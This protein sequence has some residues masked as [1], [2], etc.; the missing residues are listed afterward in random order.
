MSKD[1]ETGS[2][3]L[4]NRSARAGDREGTPEVGPRGGVPGKRAL[5]DG[6]RGP[7]PDARLRA[8]LALARAQ[9][10][11]ARAEHLPRLRGS[12]AARSMQEARTAAGDLVRT[13]AT[14][15]RELAAARRLGGEV[16][17]LTAE[18]EAL[19]AEAA[20]DLALAPPTAPPLDDTPWALAFAPP[21][22]EYVEA[23][24][25]NQRTW[26]EQLDQRDAAQA[27]AP[28]NLIDA[29]ARFPAA[30]VVQRRAG[31]SPASDPSDLHRHAAAGVAGAGGALPHLVAI[32]RSFGRHDVS[33]V[34]AHI[35][36]AAAH[37]AQAIGAEAYATGNDVAFA[38]APSL[39]TAAHEAAHVVQQQS[40]VQL[41]GGVGEAGDAHEQHADAV[42]DRV[43]RGESA[44]DLLSNSQS[45]APAANTSAGQVQRREKTD[46][47]FLDL[48]RRENPNPSRGGKRPDEDSS[49]EDKAGAERLLAEDDYKRALTAAQ[50]SGRRTLAAMAMAP[51]PVALTIGKDGCVALADHLGMVEAAGRSISPEAGTKVVDVMAIVHQLVDRMN[52]LDAGDVAEV[53]TLQAVMARVQ[54]LAPEGSLP[55]RPFADANEAAE[56]SAE[57][58]AR[59]SRASPAR[60]T[61]RHLEAARNRLD[62]ALET[63]R[64]EIVG[65]ERDV[66]KKEAI[67][68]AAVDDV[69]PWVEYVARTIDR[70]D[71]GIDADDPQIRAA[72]VEFRN[73]AQR[74][75]Y[76]AVYDPAAKEVVELIVAPVERVTSHFGLDPLRVTGQTGEEVSS[77]MRGPAAAYKTGWEAVYKAQARALQGLIDSEDQKKEPGGWDTVLFAALGAARQ[78]GVIGFVA[79]T[80]TDKLH[81]R[82]K[83]TASDAMKAIART[84]FG[85][86]SA[87]PN[88]NNTLR[89]Q[90]FYQRQVALVELERRHK[91]EFEQRDLLDA[92]RDPSAADRIEAEA[93]AAQRSADEIQARYQVESVQDW[94]TQMA[95]NRYGTNWT[96]GVDLD[97]AG[98]FEK[99]ATGVLEITARMAKPGQRPTVERAVIGS[100]RADDA[101]RLH[102]QRVGDLTLPIQVH[103]RVETFEALSF[104]VSRNKEGTVW[105]GDTTET[106]KEWLEKRGRGDALEG[107][108]LLFDDMSVMVVD[109]ESGS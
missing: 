103:G 42:A 20:A 22:A 35:G 107:A 58:D 71:L 104:V 18:L 65:K 97:N 63:F 52:Q 9:I 93:E 59:G 56:V 85:E 80:V 101:A 55:D 28:S 25:Q 72:A 99:H 53:Q 15:E 34:R 62:A 30:A 74:F 87:A 66:K 19:R 43:V 84:V 1:D 90:F 41:K 5:T 4:D 39:H 47:A 40:G 44:V 2:G 46:D 13:L 94:A 50:V 23:E 95:G 61:R 7:D 32:Q 24:R 98:A 70:N 16:D 3:F 51:G 102:G 36:G 91:L 48:A 10:S 57:N 75:V 54:A 96:G 81:G 100:F 17:G 11:V 76:W 89:Q 88:S 21:S 60:D 38:T 26:T 86:T 12:I 27:E 67:L 108:R 14:A 6:R 73:A 37:A 105:L 92:E 68:R 79:A 82:A 33:N 106:G 31:T 8:G 78:A 69:R 64:M 49:P 29:S 45:N 83:T 77:V 109:P